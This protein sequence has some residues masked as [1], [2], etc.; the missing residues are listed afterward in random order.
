MNDSNATALQ[1]VQGRDFSHF[2]DI[3]IQVQAWRTQSGTQVRFVRRPELPMVDL[4]L[5]FNAGTSLDGD[6]SGVAALTLHMLD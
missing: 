5:Y 1:S 6:T 4:M 3:R 2:D